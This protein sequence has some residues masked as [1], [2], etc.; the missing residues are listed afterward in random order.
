MKASVLGLCSLCAVLS[1][2]AQ[3][4]KPKLNIPKNIPNVTVP[5][6]LSESEIA[7]GLKE[8][9]SQGAQ[10]A[11]K[12]LN[13]T[14]G[15]NGN[16]LLRIL[17]PPEVKNMESRLRT[18]G[19]GKQVD[20]FIVLMNRAAEDAAK[21]A[22]P[23]FVQSI[24]QMTLQDAK[25]ILV[26]ADTSATAYL[27]KSTYSSLFDAFSPHIK[28]A[29]DKHAVAAKW[30][31]LANAYNSLPTTRTKVNTDLPSYITNRALSGLFVKVAEEEK[32]IRANPAARTTE[33]MR[34]VF[35]QQK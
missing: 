5:A 8:A 15:Y 19:M 30:T 23:I 29:M 7:E 18:I 33:L 20:E 17:M 2:T 32:N 25:S 4:K 1:C 9:L 3:I 13:Q 11:G 14:D 24:K 28:T 16:A 21:E 31:P 26:G 22:A 27:R 10:K 6:G 35:A 12:A 34:K